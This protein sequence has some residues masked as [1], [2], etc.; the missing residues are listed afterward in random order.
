M[1]LEVTIDAF[2]CPIVLVIGDEPIS[3][4]ILIPVIGCLK[5]SLQR[6]ELLQLCAN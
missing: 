3:R 1:L 5:E 4:H 2:L 6:G